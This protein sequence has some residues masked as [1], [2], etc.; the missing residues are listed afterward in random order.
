MGPGNGG[1]QHQAQPAQTAGFDKVPV[2]GPDWVAGDAFGADLR[3]GAS[4]YGV[5]QAENQRPR[6]DEGGEEQTEQDA[7]GLET[8]PA[9]AVQQAVERAELWIVRQPEYPQCHGHRSFSR[10]EQRTY[11]QLPGV[12]PAARYAPKTMERI[13]AGPP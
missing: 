8:G 5:A 6:G 1:Q 2:T 10:R 13:L 11:Y 7:S 9:R 4:L 3:S 12:A